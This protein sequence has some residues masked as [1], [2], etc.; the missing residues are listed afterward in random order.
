[1]SGRFDGKVAIVTG[2]G[3]GIGRATARGF[4]SDG[5]SVVIADVDPSGGEETAE[6]IG[7]DGGRAL[8]VRTDV[9]SADDVTAMVDATVREYGR[10][11]YAHNNAGIIG[12]G[13]S[14]VAMTEDVW[15][16]TI[17]TN[18]TG[19]WL[20]LKH[21][22]PAMLQ[23]GGGAHRQ[24]VVARGSPGCRGHSCVRREQTRSPGVDALRRARVRSAGE[25]VS[26]RSARARCAPRCPGWART[27]GPIRSPRTVRS[28][29]WPRSRRSPAPCCGC[30][31]TRRA[32]PRE[33][34]SRST[35]AP[36]QCEGCPHTPRATSDS[37]VMR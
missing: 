30:A 19:I 31:P 35:A 2:A 33:R 7:K 8:F 22:I 18:L 11:D 12:G 16:K 13:G 27:R 34:R 9:S 3:S 6:L 29:A 24:H 15:S 5:A 10:L 20:C 36:T 37:D 23:S 28:R 1:M 4:A 17:A 14:V 32:S 21:E 25:F 26:T